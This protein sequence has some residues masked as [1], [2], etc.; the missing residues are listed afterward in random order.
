MANAKTKTS[1]ITD[2]EFL[3]LCREE[4]K[5]ELI[6]GVMIVQSPGS[7]EHE[8]IFG[9][10]L[11]LLHL[12]VDAKNLGVVLGSRMAVRLSEYDVLEPDILFIGRENVGRIKPNL[13]DGPCDL[14]IEILSPGSRSYDTGPKKALYER[15]RV[16]EY[17]VIDPE[18]RTVTFYQLKRGLYS[19][20]LPDEKGAYHSKVLSGFWLCVQWLWQ[21]PAPSLLEIAQEL[22]L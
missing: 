22:G 6:D 2:K 11:S 4:D 1:I 17:W 5:A 9:F 3:E 13:V 15:Y 16:A 21:D 20:V 8:K 12:Y 19:T 7:Y 10:L 14:A 18:A